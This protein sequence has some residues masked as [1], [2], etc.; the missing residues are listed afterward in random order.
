MIQQPF[1]I[2]FLLFGSGL[3]AQSSFLK[4]IE[5]I[6]CWYV[7][8]KDAHNQPIWK[9]NI[10][11]QISPQAANHPKTIQFVNFNNAFYFNGRNESID[12]ALAPLDLSKATFF[13]VYQT[14]DMLAEYSIW[15]FEK[16]DLPQLV[17]TSHRIADLQ[18]I[19]YIHFSNVD[20]KQPQ[21]NTYLQHLPKDP[22]PIFNQK[23]R[24][25]SKPNQHLPV[26]FFKGR[27]AEIMIFDKVL[28]GTEQNQ[29]ESYLALK[30]GLLLQG[31]LVNGKGDKI[32][33][34]VK[35]KDYTGHLAGIGRDDA[36]GLYQKQSSSSLESRLLTVGAGAIAPSNQANKTILLDN[37]FLIWG[38]NQGDLVFDVAKK[39]SFSI[40]NRK[41]LMT[42]QG[43][44]TPLTTMLHFDT[45]QIRSILTKNTS[46][47]L[48]IDRRGKGDFI[49][50]QWIK[51]DSVDEKGI[52]IFKKVDWDT[53]GSGTDVFTIATTT[54]IPKS[55]W[56][57]YSNG[58][59]QKMVLYPNPTENGYFTL[60]VALQQ[61][62]DV[63]MEVRDML[64]KLVM[65]QIKNGSDYYVFEGQLKAETT[66]FVTVIAEK[67]A[68]SLKIV[69]H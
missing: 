29:V 65:R 25:G 66:Y 30:Y 57:P 63:V 47:Y 49:D 38:D 61:T 12:L 58:V 14:E 32:W 60:R 37:T 27:L 33:D 51:A 16:N 64:G 69:V 11:H 23:L 44:T 40:L 54:A 21:I 35:N 67:T 10:S 31:S 46:F 62:D 2:F 41:W 36:T 20:K 4:D 42:V 5:G 55:V 1:W 52:A 22:I 7:A 19:Q 48:G 6:K 68:Q 39:D 43:Q 34:L 50:N 53:D 56:Q 13:T 26:S 28:T 24:L 18:A 3:M 15:H 9:N 17:L 8:E 59:I 45:Q